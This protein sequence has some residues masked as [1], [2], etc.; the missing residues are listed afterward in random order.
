MKVATAEIWHP[1]RECDT[2]VTGLPSKQNNDVLAWAEA[3]ENSL[4][5]LDADRYVS[6]ID[7][8]HTAHGRTEKTAC[9]SLPKFQSSLGVQQQ[10]EGLQ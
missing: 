9:L 5:W 2:H 1:A 10:L 8:T 7:S 3:M 4:F 6:P